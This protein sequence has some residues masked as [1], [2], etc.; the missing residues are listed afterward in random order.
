LR[1]AALALLLSLPSAA[2]AGSDQAEFDRDFEEP[3]QAP[4]LTLG[5]V[6][7]GDMTFGVDVGWLRSGVQA[8]LGL[9]S[10]LDIL[11][12]ADAM[13]LYQA[14]DAQNAFQVGFRFSPDLAPLRAGL[15]IT[16]GRIFIPLPTN[17]VW[18]TTFRGELAT[19]FSLGWVAPYGRL[20]VRWVESGNL[21]FSRWGMDVVA[22]AGV[23]ATP[24]P[25]R[26]LILGAE[27]GSW[28]REGS[29]PLLQWRLRVGY[30][31]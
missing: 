7:A 2:L 21:E 11:L 13:L 12:R 22:G 29:K 31:I 20:E 10:F 24:F 25:R 18:L 5:P 26:R 16:A 17:A 27:I 19:G 23:E 28:A 3:P 14:F 4:S 30:A 6:G 15:E 8:H 9:L 1:A